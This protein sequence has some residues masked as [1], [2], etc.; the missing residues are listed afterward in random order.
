LATRRGG[1]LEFA[2][3]VAQTPRMRL[4]QYLTEVQTNR[5]Q[6]KE[7]RAFGIAGVL[8]ARYDNVYGAYLRDLRSHVKRRSLIALI[9][10]VA[11]AAV[12]AGTLLAIIWLVA[13][14]SL[15][16]AGAGAAIVAVRLLAGQISSL[17]SSVAQVFE[18]GLFLEDLNEFV[19]LRRP[20]EEDDIRGET[21]PTSFQRLDVERLNFT[22]PGST[23]PALIDVDLHVDAGE[24]IA[25]VGENGSGKTTLAKLLATLYEPDSGTIRW[26]G[27]DTARYQRR[28]LRRATAVIFQD[29]VRYQ[30]PV[31]DNIGF[32]R[33]DVAIDEA[34]LAQAAQRAGA[35]SAI[36]SLPMGYDTILSK[37]FAGG[38]E[39]SGGQWQ[40]IALAR[41]F[42]RDSPFV[43]LDEPTSALD[44][45]A[46][47]ELFN[48]LRRLL[49]GRTVIF[50]S[51]RMA[52][53][54]DA[55]RIYVLS[56]GRIAEH[57]TH[58]DLMA[59]RG[60]YADL[61]DLQAAAFEKPNT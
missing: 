56:A 28:G 32:G 24:V 55:D 18:S 22:Y 17:F 9:S 23:S 14:H 12:L 4:R 33:P 38:R 50:V 11:S 54:R 49:A 51:H 3:A 31:R 42:Y 19:D 59:E 35:E 45:R 27:V 2:F 10:S 58:A 39:L 43:I 13:R 29:F 44:P 40:R 57:G 36:A 53:V 52:T 20:A 16:L 6:A 5:D 30:L 25:L 15:S 46:E 1:N 34:E 21:A 48:S 60:M 47:H 61:F 7:V 41:A 37:A 8:R 26:D